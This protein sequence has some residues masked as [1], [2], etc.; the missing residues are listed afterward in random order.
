MSKLDKPRN[1]W[2]KALWI[3]HQSYMGG[4]NMNKVL[5]NFS[6]NFWKFQTRISDICKAHPRFKE[7]LQKTDVPFK[8]KVT[9]KTGYTTWY[10]PLH[11][12]PYILNLYNKINKE[13]LKTKK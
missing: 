3:L 9:G 1:D 13:G 10:T 7:K 8:D 2:A 4:V 6:P 11:P 12:K 5:N